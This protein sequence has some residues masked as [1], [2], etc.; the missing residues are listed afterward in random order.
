[1]NS[2]DIDILLCYRGRYHAQVQQ[3]DRLL[4]SHNL[5]V[6]YDSEILT[7]GAPYV[8][9]QVE[10]MSLGGPDTDTGTTWRGPLNAAVKR[11]A[12]IVFLLDPRDQS[13]NVMNEI[14][15]AA[16]SGKPLFVV[17]DV[18][19]DRISEE[20]E[21]VNLGMM[22]AFYGL[23]AQTA[24]IAQRADLAKGP[25]IPAFGYAFVVHENDSGLGDRLTVLANRILSYFGRVRLGDLEKIRL[26]NQVTMS[27][28]E[29]APQARAQR[30]LHDV[31]QKIGKAVGIELPP[32]ANDKLTETLEKL[33]S[34]ERDGIVRNGRIYP[35]DSAFSYPEESERERYRRTEA[36]INLIRPSG[37]EISDFLAM[38]AREL[39]SL[40][41][42]QPQR[43]R[44][45]VL[46]GS[47]PFCPSNVP[48]DFIL[49]PDFAVLLADA[50]YIDFAY[51]MLKVAVMSWKITSAP[52]ALPVS[53]STKLDD[54]KATIA[55]NFAL[56]RGIARCLTGM[57]EKGKPGSSTDGMPPVMYHP[58]LS[59]LGVF[60][61]RFSIA[62]ALARIAMLNLR[63]AR[64]PEGAA[65]PAS[66]QE[67]LFYADALAAQW[68][69]QGARIL[70]GTDP[71]VAL[72]GILLSLA[73]QSLLE[74]SLAGLTP[75]EVI[76][77]AERMKRVGEFFVAY[78][79]KSGMSREEAESRRQGSER[80]ATTL[81]LLWDAAVQQQFIAPA[82][83]KPAP[84][85][86]S[87]KRQEAA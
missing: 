22:Q 26:D 28:V 48:V 17:F 43:V 18:K 68:V 8:E 37:F 58:A 79:V 33:Y 34:R 12:M 56:A 51:Q 36:L 52:G 4:V 2:D 41:M 82:S 13:P 66:L 84:R 10:W 75:P 40:E 25:E 70:D 77:A 63:A 60:Q 71:T 81:D 29:N 69:L 72:Q 5:K 35:K 57:V 59:M 46:I 14:A 62:T 6:T 65:N 9:A 50:T 47:V 64:Q 74:R 19:G 24:D 45:C 49:D 32:D 73:A 86:R 1:M 54:T 11:S 39:V 67:W 42:V 44:G 20:Y 16:R 76:P 7:P 85:W 15:W 55:A 61:K 31:Q 38:L 3:L 87:I 30:R 78:E 83:L 23:S 21:G 80:V 27:D 53:M